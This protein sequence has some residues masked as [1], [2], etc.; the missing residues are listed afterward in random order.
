MRRSP[1]LS[2]FVT[3]F[4]LF[5]ALIVS[6]VLSNAMQDVD[7]AVVPEAL[8][9]SEGGDFGI[10]MGSTCKCLYDDLCDAAADWD[11]DLP[12]LVQDDDS[13]DSEDD[14]V[15]EDS[16]LCSFEGSHFSRGMGSARRCL[17]D[18]L[19]AAADTPAAA[20][21]STEPNRIE[22]NNYVSEDSKLL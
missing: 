8:H 14:W 13:S 7:A 12:K 16:G 6:D 21:T 5:A 3:C 18:D 20:D 19:S 11:S 10:D 9:S 15:P 22:P 1:L 2:L 4:F 17:Y